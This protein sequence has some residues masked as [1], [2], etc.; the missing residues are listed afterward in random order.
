MLVDGASGF[1]WLKRL[2]NCASNFSPV[3]SL[4]LN[5]LPSVAE[6][7]VV[8]DPSRMPTPQ[9]PKRPMLLAGMA[10]PLMLASDGVPTQSGRC[11]EV[12]PRTSTPVPEGSVPLKV[13]VRYGPDWAS[14]MPATLH[15]PTTAFERLPPLLAYFFPWPTGMSQKKVFKKR[16]RRVK[17]TLP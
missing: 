7:T 15:P 1:R 10:K 8:P 17:T 5:C 12:T 6:N 3:R 2:A 13:G 4:N 9:F 16:L 14:R 11:V